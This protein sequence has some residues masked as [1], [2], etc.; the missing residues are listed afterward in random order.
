MRQQPS[1][2][3]NQK[4]VFGLNGS[5]IYICEFFSHSTRKHLN[6]KNVFKRTMHTATVLFFLK[7]Y[8]KALALFDLIDKKQ[9]IYQTKTGSS[10][11]EASV[12]STNYRFIAYF[13]VRSL[14]RL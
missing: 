2:M 8:L 6:D 1:N 5:Q 13:R 9:T 10:E 3:N 4:N 7:F 12:I 14:V 11:K